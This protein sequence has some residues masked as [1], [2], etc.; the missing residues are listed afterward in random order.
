MLAMLPEVPVR[1]YELKNEKRFG[2][3]ASD[4]YAKIQKCCIH[5]RIL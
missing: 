3:P 4:S 1:K 2:R 5:C